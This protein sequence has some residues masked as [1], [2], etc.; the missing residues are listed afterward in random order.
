MPNLRCL[1]MN[2]LPPAMHSLQCRGA[3]A[4]LHSMRD[5]TSAGVVQPCFSIAGLTPIA[6]DAGGAE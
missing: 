1:Y 5:V 4:C 3:S 6:C 2:L